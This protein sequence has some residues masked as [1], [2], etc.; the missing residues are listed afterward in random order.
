MNAKVVLIFISLQCFSHYHSLPS[1]HNERL[2][3]AQS[4]HGKGLA[5]GL[6][7]L[8]SIEKKL[9][10]VGK[11]LTCSLCKILTGLLQ[12][13]LELGTTEES[14]VN[15]LT[16]V[17]IDLKIEDVTVCH[18]VIREFKEEV[19]T[20]FDEAVVTP[21]DVCGTILGPSCAKSGSVYGP[22]NVTFHKQVRG[23]RTRGSRPS[24]FK[25]QGKVPNFTRF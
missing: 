8:T 7:A 17:C 14:V 5:L 2:N 4:N 21:D 25:V 19:L 18:G 24:G 16:T 10:N 20:V 22:W 9:G 11:G 1:L 15:A 13:Y 12:S 6:N 3:H 23:R